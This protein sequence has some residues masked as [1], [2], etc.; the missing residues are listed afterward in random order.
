V[1]IAALGGIAPGSRNK[2][3]WESRASRAMNLL[4]PDFINF[5]KAL[6]KSCNA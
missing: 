4:I 1:V 2:P 5:S 6:G 3:A